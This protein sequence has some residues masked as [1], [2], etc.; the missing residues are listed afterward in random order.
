MSDSVAM[1]AGLDAGRM[2]QRIGL[3]GGCATEART[4]A[5]GAP[6]VRCH[7]GRPRGSVFD[8]P[9]AGFVCHQRSIALYS[10]IV[11]VASDGTA[12]VRFDIPEFAG[13]VR[14]MAVAWSKD[15]VGR[16]SGDVS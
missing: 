7:A 3:T 13:T 8:R 1:F 10:G 6:Y 4:E 5:V 16:A 2:V 15:N 14:V 9:A 12:E 11:R